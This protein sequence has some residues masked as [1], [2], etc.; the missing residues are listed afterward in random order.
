MIYLD[1]RLVFV[2]FAEMSKWYAYFLHY[3]VM[4]RWRQSLKATKL[5]ALQQVKSLEAEAKG[6]AHRWKVMGKEAV[7]AQRNAHMSE[8]VY[9]RHEDLMSDAAGDVAN[10]AENKAERL[11]DEAQLSDR[12]T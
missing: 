12:L 8:H 6:L 1:V 2:R 7:K 10:R 9:E 5:K 3:Y 11:R 4:L